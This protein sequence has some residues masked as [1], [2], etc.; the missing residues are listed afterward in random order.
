VST[1]FEKTLD[2][3]QSLAAEYNRTADAPVSLALIGGL[4]LGAWGV[5]RATRDVDFLLDAGKRQG[6]DEF[7]QF[8]SN[9]KLRC[10]SI[11]SSPDDPLPWL[12]E[13]LPGDLPVP[14]H[15]I[16]ATRK[17]ELE[18]FLKRNG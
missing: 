7:L 10:N 17:T 4:A 1:R 6:V 9:R 16:V 15:L 2:R 13:V 11:T 12:V 18:A 8:L 5:V 3:L 14:V